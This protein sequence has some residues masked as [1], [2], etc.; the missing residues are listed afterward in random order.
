MQLPLN[1]KYLQLTSAFLSGFS[2]GYLICLYKRKSKPTNGESLLTLP[3]KL[4]FVQTDNV[5][6]I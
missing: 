4:K 1:N 3:N 5:L 2:A 6:L